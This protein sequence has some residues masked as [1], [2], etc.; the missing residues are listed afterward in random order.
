MTKARIKKLI[1]K[2]HRYMGLFLGIQFLF[3][4]LGGLYFSWSDIREIRGEDIRNE[5]SSL[6]LTGK[7]VPPD[8]VLNE[9]RKKYAILRLISVQLIDLLGQPY[10]QVSFQ[11]NQRVKAVLASAITGELKGPL[12]EAEAIA[13]A[14]R[15]LIHPV[16]P[17][18][19][20]YIT[21]TNGH[22]EYRGKAL[23]AYAVTFKEDMNST[24]YVSTEMGTVQSFRNNRWRVFDILWMMHTMDYQGRDNFNNWILRIF[25]ALGLLAI[26][27]GFMLYFVSIPK[28]RK[29]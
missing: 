28:S 16:E 1:R 14:K 7:Y 25:S 23:P 20:T 17:A 10:Y 6:V 4:T 18:S 26:I 24:V 15:S 8:S 12:N 3:W 29:S 11:T 22:H 19:V 13:V 27:S 9:A 5:G 2:A 21:E